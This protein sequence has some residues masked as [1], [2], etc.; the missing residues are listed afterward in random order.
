MAYRFLT[1]QF[2]KNFTHKYKIH[3]VERIRGYIKS[4]YGK[5]H[6]S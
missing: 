2:E 3:Y 1:F 4:G 6:K 5:E